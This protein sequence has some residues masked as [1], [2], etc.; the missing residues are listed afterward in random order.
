MF[1]LVWVETHGIRE[2]GLTLPYAFHDVGGFAVLFPNIILQLQCLSSTAIYQNAAVCKCQPMMAGI[3]EGDLVQVCGNFRCHQN[4]PRSASPVVFSPQGPELFVAGICDPA[5]Y[6]VHQR[7]VVLD[8]LS[9]HGDHSGPISPGKEDGRLEQVER[10]E[11]SF[12]PGVCAEGR[13][14]REK[15][16]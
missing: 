4:R 16:A 6:F 15:R 11:D 13:G 1:W 7:R 10:G 14:K 8:L 5:R 2:A 12:R 3:R 9:R